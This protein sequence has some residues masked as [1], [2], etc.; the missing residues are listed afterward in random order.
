MF[1]EF[2]ETVH[3]EVYTPIDP[4]TTLSGSMKDKNII[5][6]G[7]LPREVIDR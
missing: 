5:I 1:A 2:T 7:L 3:H 6:T 4:K